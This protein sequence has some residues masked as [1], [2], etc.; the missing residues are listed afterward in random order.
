MKLQTY[1]IRIYVCGL[2]A[3][4][5]D[6]DNL[7]KLEKGSYEINDAN[8]F[9]TTNSLVKYC[10]FGV[11]PVNSLCIT[12][13]WPKSEVTP[14]VRRNISSAFKIIDTQKYSDRGKFKTTQHFLT[15]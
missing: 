9:V 5:P 12:V 15:R 7:E 1:V 2:K 13:Q 11:S 4:L 6:A 14:T 3:V 10:H 8:A